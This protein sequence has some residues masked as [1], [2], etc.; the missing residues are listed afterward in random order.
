MTITLHDVSKNTVNL[1]DQAGIYHFEH[2]FSPD[3]GVMNCTCKME[4][5]KGAHLSE[6]YLYLEGDGKCAVI[7]N[8]L[9]TY[10]EM[11]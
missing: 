3:G 11:M 9:Y 5:I 4:G 1:I 2:S 6:Y 10:L 8:R 7:D